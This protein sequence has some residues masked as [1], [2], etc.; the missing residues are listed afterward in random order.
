M[1]S[2][3]KVIL[4]GNLGKDPEVKYTPGGMAVARFSIATN[5][6]FKGKD[7]NWEDRTEWHNVVLFD[8]KA[9]VAG[10]Y[11]KKGRTVYIEGSIRTNSW[12][13]R[14][15][16]RRSIGQRLS[17]TRWCFLAA[18]ARAVEKAA[19][20]AP[21]TAADAQEPSPVPAQADSTSARPNTKVR[22]RS[23]T[24]VRRSR[25]KIFRSKSLCG[26]GA[27]LADAASASTKNYRSLRGTGVASSV[28][29]T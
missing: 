20:A 24:T 4:I 29:L 3:N 9:E 26:V 28:P 27:A 5:E 23:A 6:R 12:D 25:T 22:R 14:R 16:V 18:N 15:P 10:E 1:A 21:G 8:R 7:G 17:A 13:D 19:K 2:V 11:L